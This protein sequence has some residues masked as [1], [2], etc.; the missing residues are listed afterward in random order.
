MNIRNDYSGNNFGKY[1][2]IQKLG[3]GGFGSVYKVYDKILGVEKALKIMEVS[4]PNEA[5]KLFSEAAIPYKCQHNNVIK[6]N[7]GEII[8][9]NGELLFVID[10][11]LANGKS[12]ESILKTS[13]LSIIQSL[14]IIRNVLF[15][16]EYSHLQGIIHRDI[17]PANI[18]IDNDIP[19][20]ADFG[21]STALGKTI[22]PWK[23]YVTHAAPE[24]FVNNSIATVQTDIFA[25][26]MTLYRMVN[27]I[28]DWE[29]FLQSIPDFNEAIPKG[30][31]INKLPMSPI[32]PEKI[33]RIVKKACNIDPQKRYNSAS[34]MRNAIEKLQ[35]LYSWIKISEFNWKGSSVG[36]PKKE[37]CIEPNK[38]IIN[39]SVYNNNRK[40][41]SDSKKFTEMMQAKDY[42]NNY[43]RQTTIK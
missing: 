33:V 17:K 15:A 3:N 39:V 32:V 8:K 29:F 31:L 10:M 42:V 13:Y 40:S 26:G 41:S 36:S 12:I 1:Y 16:V 7:G 5:Y 9:Y 4:N 11:D 30:T 20:L 24:T 34:E 35:P 27:G 2:L 6:I 37:I 23:W 21:L 19:K 43:I 18:L 22:I 14:E 38:K 25:L 28:S